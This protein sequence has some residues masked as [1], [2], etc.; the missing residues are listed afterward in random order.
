MSLTPPRSIAA[1]EAEEAKA[2]QEAPSIAE[3]QSAL[4]YHV[5]FIL[6]GV[7]H[8]V[9]HI[10]EKMAALLLS[11]PVIVQC[12]APLDGGPDNGWLYDAATGKFSKPE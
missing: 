6:D 4:P 11:N 10:E 9:F 5:A 8:N 3:Q 2:K 1:I 12:D 7:V